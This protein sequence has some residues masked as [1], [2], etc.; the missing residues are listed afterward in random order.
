MILNIKD[1]ILESDFYKNLV[2]NK[3]IILDNSTFIQFDACFA[4]GLMGGVLKKQPT[5]GSVHL[6]FG[7]ALHEALEAKFKEKA[8]L[9]EQIRRA[10]QHPGFSKLDNT[11]PIKTQQSLRDLIVSYHIHT[12]Q[13]QSFDVLHLGGEPCVELS[14]R[15]FLGNIEVDGFWP[16]PQTVEVYWQ[17]K[18]DALG[19][20]QNEPWIVDH[21][22]TTM[23]GEKFADTYL[24]SS[25]MLG[26]LWAGRM[27]IEQGL[28]EL[29]TESGKVYNLAEKPYRGVLINTLCIRKSGAEFKCFPIPI[30]QVR[31]SEWVSETLLRLKFLTEQFKTFLEVDEITPTR[32]HCVTKYGRCPFFDVCE[33][34]IKMR[35]A[36]LTSQ[37]FTTSDWSPL[38]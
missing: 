30:P 27:L 29:T 25:Q 37:M 31:L 10:E 15:I 12:E 34:P 26:Y 5:G 13:M 2:E 7:G 33:A 17:G 38:D 22:S 3:T 20:Y 32:E 35:K 14:F 21:K 28:G 36:M 24:R 8:D 23:M 9:P 18:I 6:D 1:E 4:K 16:T 19:V 11:H